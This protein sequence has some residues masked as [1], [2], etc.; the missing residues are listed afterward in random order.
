MAFNLPSPQA[1][2][3]SAGSVNVGT[4]GSATN[5][6]T[7]SGGNLPISAN[8][9][10]CLNTT[11]SN[12]A[13]TPAGVF[14]GINGQ[15][16]TTTVD[17]TTEAKV[18]VW[19]LQYNAPNRI[20]SS[21]LANGGSRLRIGSG[22]NPTL[23]YK[24]YYIGGNDTP[25]CSAQAG[26]VTMCIDL[27]D[28]SH[29]NEVGTFDL[30]NVSAYGHASVRFNLVGGS[31]TQT[32]FQRSFLFTT[33]K[34]SANIPKFTGVSSF[35]DAVALLQG[36][37]YTTK[38]GSW[39]TKSG[40]S[41]FLPCPFQIGDGSSAT[42][43]N[44][45]GAAIVSPASN[46][47]GQENF[48][49]TDDAMRVYANLRDNA[50]D[51]ITLSGSYSWGTAANWNFNISN[52][53]SINIDGATFSGMG[54]FRV[55]SSVSGAATFNLASGKPVK[56]EDA[57]DLTGSTIN[58]DCNLGTGALTTLE[59]L[60]ITGVLDFEVAGT[61]TATNCNI[62]EVTNSSGGAVTITND[63]STISTNTG[64]SITIVNPPTTFTIQ[65]NKTG[66]DVVI[67]AAGTNTV[68]A[69][70]D[71][72]AGNDFVW[73]YVGAQTVDIGVIKP[74]FIV[75]YTYGYQLAGD[76][77]SLP[78]NLLVDRDYI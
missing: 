27:S 73:T 42:T 37:D 32:F 5:L 10:Q 13:G 60:T 20:Q 72:Q 30:A 14:F 45:N 69:S 36:T 44:D 6:G 48:R 35:D 78:V 22:S 11:S 12:A 47:A 3:T 2:H 63:G 67:L 57:A 7:K 75:N 18:L 58:G 21:T 40:S 77:Q 8:A 56:I 70:V 51:S 1:L 24:D 23:N 66:A 74:G 28:T 41:I 55:G 46:L 15:S 33:A 59:S 62:N 49:L 39:I 68:L 4:L 65:V 17:G 19:S 54:G 50:A 16:A 53:A 34:D 43:F 31:T 38:I 76:N 71:A 9:S 61:Y 52:N 25:F 26:P 64:P 29:N